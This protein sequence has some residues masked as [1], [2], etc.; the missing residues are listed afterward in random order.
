ML[1]LAAGDFGWLKADLLFAEEVADFTGDGLV[2]GDT[3]GIRQQR[4]HHKAAPELVALVI[5]QVAGELQQPDILDAAAS[6]H[7][8]A[9]PNF[10]GLAG[11]A[12][13]SGSAV[14]GRAIQLEDTTAIFIGRD[15]EQVRVEKHGDILRAL[16]LLAEL[17]LKVVQILFVLGVHDSAGQLVAG[18][19]IKAAS[20]KHT[21]PEGHVVII[22]GAELPEVM[23]V[24]VPGRQLALIKEPA[25]V[26]I[27][28]TRHGVG[29]VERARPEAEVI[30][31]AAIH[32]QRAM[33]EV[34]IDLRQKVA[35][36]AAVKRLPILVRGAAIGWISADE[37]EDLQRT[38]RQT[39]RHGDAGRASAHDA[40]IEIA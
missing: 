21:F 7:I 13:A 40:D 31:R 29:R 28:G 2:E 15:G 12:P 26:A 20:V 39:L 4:M 32:I 16:E 19:P 14:Y 35:D 10:E 11:S 18:Q 30:G 36:S 38:M 27:A 34:R 23:S 5:A 3:A 33:Q 24:D 9:R 1:I 37:Q 22:E 8:S 25:D 6:H 17:H